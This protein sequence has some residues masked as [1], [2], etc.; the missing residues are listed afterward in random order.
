M[1]DTAIFD[2]AE[3][4]QAR[5]GQVVGGSNQVHIGAPIRNEIG[6]SMASLFLF[7]LQVNAELRNE[8]RHAVPPPFEP[9][10]DPAIPQDAL[11]F[12][13]RFLITVFRT[14]DAT[15]PPNELTTLG[16]IIQTLQAQPTL[17]GQNLSGQVVRMTP[18][19]YPIEELSRVWGLFPQDVYRTSVVYLASPVFIDARAEPAGP[20]VQ[21]REQR[22]G[23]SSAPPDPFGPRE[24]AEA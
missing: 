22:A 24:A 15:A 20:P 6:Q 19:P 10:T 9:A 18:E 1:T 14:P 5:V 7:H 3:A 4:L 13:L 12:D 21:R 11:P 8:L 2:V 16:R 17:V 23:L